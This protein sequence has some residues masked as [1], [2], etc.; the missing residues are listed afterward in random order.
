MAPEQLADLSPSSQVPMDVT[1]LDDAVEPDTGLDEMELRLA[2][3]S[4]L[5]RLRSSFP[6]LPLSL[7]DCLPYLASFS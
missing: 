6:S 7:T 4:K 5:V 3:L 2:Q 1:P